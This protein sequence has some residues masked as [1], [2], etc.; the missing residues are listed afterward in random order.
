MALKIL[1][2]DKDES[3]LDSAGKYLI[4][5][6]YEVKCVTTGKEVQMAL[7]DGSIFAVVMNYEIKNHS[8]LQVIRFIKVNYPSQK[9]IVVLDH[10]NVLEG[11]DD[12]RLSK[13]G[14]RDYLMRPFDDEKLK[15]TLEGQQTLSELVSSLPK[16]TGVSEEQEVMES[17]GKFSKVRIGEFFSSKA[18]LFDVYIRLGPAR[19]VKILHAGDTFSKER[20]DHYKNEKKIEHLYFNKNDRKKFVQYHNFLGKKIVKSGKIPGQVKLNLMRNVS[21]KYIEDAFTE[22]V[23][24]Q[25]VEQGK[26]ICE[27]I[28]NLV[29]NEKGLFKVLR[30]FIDFDPNAFS[31]AYL[32]SIFTTAIIK[33]FEWQSKATIETTALA[34]L[35]HDIGKMKLPKEFI[36][37]KSSEMN[38]A[39]IEQYQKHPQLGV[40][41]VEGSP[42]MGQSVK[43][44][45]LQHHEAY[46][47]T[48]FPHMIKGEKILTL[49][50]IVGLANNFVH[51]LTEEEIKPV[52]GLKKMLGSQS[53]VSKY[54][55]QIIEKFINVFV[56]PEKIIKKHFLPSNSRV[57]N[58]S[59]KVS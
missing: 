33:Q 27:N 42:L 26:E 41:I 40:E 56:D 37:M 9:L 5:L 47:G 55:S 10:K 22:G 7:Y 28:Y 13:L 2:A 39:Q 32:T 44:I 38:E 8:G 54:N 48:G 21:E 34:C 14:V 49:S 18:V 43:Q 6:G 51:I 46:D 3:W 45:I 24:P 25:V 1:L 17:D 36:T 19:F 30:D 16:R 23:R 59:K 20:L 15:Y 52:E 4:E 53:I 11:M 12:E 35:F 29:E 31:H 50:N 57:L 58:P